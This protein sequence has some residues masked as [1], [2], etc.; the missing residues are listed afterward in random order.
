MILE[1]MKTQFR[2]NSANEKT[3]DGKEEVKSEEKGVLFYTR[4]ARPGENEDN[5]RIR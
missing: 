1:D 3:R 2:T 5:N 4:D